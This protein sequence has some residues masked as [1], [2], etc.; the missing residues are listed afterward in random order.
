MLASK[1]FH[2]LEEWYKHMCHA[3]AKRGGGISWCSIRETNISIKTGKR[4]LCA[5]PVSN[6]AI[7]CF[8]WFKDM[9]C[10]MIRC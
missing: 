5:G 1:L 10:A 2:S 8:E 3:K 4:I 9:P 7:F 6:A